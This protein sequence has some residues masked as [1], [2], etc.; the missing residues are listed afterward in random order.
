MVRR[1]GTILT[2]STV[3]AAIAIAGCGSLDEQ[4]NENGTDGTAVQ[5]T[6]GSVVAIDRPRSVVPNE[7]E[8]EDIQVFTE[9]RG[10]ELPGD[11]GTEARNPGRYD[12]SSSLSEGTI[13][14]GT[15]VDVVYVHAD[16][17]DSSE[18]QLEGT[19]EFDRK[20]DGIIAT[21]ES[22]LAA[23]E[24][25]DVA[26]LSTEYPE[27]TASNFGVNM[28][29]DAFEIGSDRKSL[30]LDYEVYGASDSMRVVFEK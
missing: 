26:S 21:G 23:N 17:P 8:S 10:Y 13:A 15:S 11:L 12:S 27:S 20:I 18:D 3:V 9:R 16:T 29:V 24:V 6:D 19:V 22:M 5:N 4:V 1:F 30:K 14:K 7:L 25:I 28:K 2:L